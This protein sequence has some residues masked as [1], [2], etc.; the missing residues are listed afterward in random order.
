MEAE[1]LK[2]L[3]S[4]ANDLVNLKHHAVYIRVALQME[5]GGET[6]AHAR[7]QM[8]GAV[9]AT[10]GKPYVIRRVSGSP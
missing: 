9:P 2:A 8:V 4:I 6:A 7:S 1:L 3:D 10:D 5:D